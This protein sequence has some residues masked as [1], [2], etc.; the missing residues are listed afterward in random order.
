M[1]ENPQTTNLSNLTVVYSRPDWYIPVTVTGF[2][3]LATFWILF[4]LIHHGIISNKWKRRSLNNYDK[5]NARLVYS[6]VVVCTVLCL[7][8]L[9]INIIYMNVGFTTETQQNQVCNSLFDAMGIVYGLLIMSTYTFLWLRQRVFYVNRMLNVN[10][11][12][13]ARLFSGISIFVIVF[14]GVC[15]LIFSTIPNDHYSTSDGCDYEPNKE[16]LVGYYISIVFVIVFGNTSLFGLFAHGLK[17]ANEFSIQLP[18]LEGRRSF[19]NIETITNKSFDTIS[20]DSR[21]SGAIVRMVDGKRSI[22]LVTHSVP[23]PTNDLVKTVLKK[24]LFFAVISVVCDIILQVLLFFTTTHRRLTTLGFNIN[25]FL[26]VL[27]IVFS[28][29]QYKKM[30]FSPCLT[31]RK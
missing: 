15:V 12:N 20:K 6:S 5:L 8:R 23:I 14:F 22:R 18:H 7:I 21:T 25:A 4:S 29:V 17:K 31:K 19:D 11:T 9:I 30:L 24:T 28:F 16:L 13:T 10:Y 2:L 26:N 27:F 1:T 3:I